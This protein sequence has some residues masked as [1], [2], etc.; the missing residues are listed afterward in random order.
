MQTLGI[1]KKTDGGET[2]DSNFFA[3]MSRMKYIKRWAL[4]RN[5]EKENVSEHSL[6]VA[7]IAHGLAVISNVRLGNNLNVERA[8]L[9]SLFHD[10]TE[11][12][13]GDMPTPVKY[14]NDE[15]KEAFKEVEKKA[16]DKLINYLPEDMKEYYEPLFF[17]SEEDAYLWKLEKGEYLTSNAQS[18]CNNNVPSILLTTSCH[19]NAFDKPYLCLSEAFIQNPQSGVVVFWGSSREGWGHKDSINHLH[20]NSIEYSC[21]FYRSLFRYKICRFGKIVTTIKDSRSPTSYNPYRWLHFSLNAIGDPELPI[22][23]ESPKSIEGLSWVHKDSNLYVTT[24]TTGC[25]I[26]LSSANDNGDSYY[27]IARD[28]CRYTFQN[29]DT[30]EN[31]Q[32]CITKDNYKPILITNLKS[33]VII[34]NQTFNSTSIVTGDEIVIGSNIS[35][36]VEEGPVVIE[37]GSTTFDATNSVTIKNGFEC[38]MG[39]TLEIK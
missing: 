17:K 34:Q 18:L 23:I 15:I 39:A 20:K 12:I 38:K 27:H 3:M 9:I 29:V 14:Y 31:Y 2:M 6:E 25:T 13:T 36:A 37:S 4:M 28:T 35:S 22:Y 10:S 26:I 11:I 21:K 8:A 7:M 32:L 16:A 19:S 24:N 5:S 30:L 33:N 1:F